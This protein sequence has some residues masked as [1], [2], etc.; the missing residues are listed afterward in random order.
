MSPDNAAR[1]DRRHFGALAAGTLAGAA[2][3][4][5]GGGLTLSAGRAEA[6]GAGCTVDPNAP[7]QQLRGVWVASVTNIDW[8]S[9]P[10]LPAAQQ[11]AELI[12]W[13]DLVNRLRLNT[14][15]L[16]V[17]P[18]ADAFWPSPYEPWSQYLTGT[19]G[20]DPGY[21]PLRFAVAAAHE[22]DIE[23][24][25]WFN[26]YRVS[27]QTDLSKLVPTHPARLHPDWVFPYGTTL[28][29][30]PGIPAVRQFVE[31]AILDAA[32]HYDIDGI[33]FDDYFYPYPIAGQ[34]LPDQATFASH[35]AGWDTIEDWRRNNINL[36]ISELHE[37]VHKIK[38]WLKFGVSPFGIW[39]NAS[40]DPAGSDTAGTQSYDANFADTRKWV[41]EQWLDYINP[42][43]YWNIGFAVADY[44]KL[45][46]WWSDQVTGTHVQLYLG[47]ANYKVG[48]PAQPAA[49]QDP[50]ELSRHLTLDQGLNVDGNVYFSA[51][52]V[53]ADVL[54][55]MSRLVADHYQHPALT[56][57]MPH[58]GG[59]APQPPA[60][61]R[62]DGTPGGVR[63]S[64]LDTDRPGSAASY[65]VY[66]F[67]GTRRLSD[68]DTAD[69]TSL[70]ATVRTAGRGQTY[71]DTTA[72]RGKTYSYAVSAVSRLSAE[73][74][75][76]AVRHVRA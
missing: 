71:T 50:A 20:K 8:P 48:N 44:A 47:E 37:R 3:L 30:N 27:L 74:R 66:R 19:Q 72:I 10:G 49:W 65:A 40:A 68:C 76:S 67:D 63:L 14:V 5:A 62:V 53:R 69:A 23:L 22:R 1:L 28:Y 34:T 18:T 24:H 60:I 73:S 59:R 45:A 58:L 12:A 36:L 13:F 52:D 41:R 54:G 9:K 43:I 4:A 6:A 46:S 16:Q 42:Q 57:A 29:Y 31:Q 7:K 61:A 11:Q 35:G 75:P 17:R 55:S 38:P 15:M 56:P 26:P 21:D 25:A 70:I 51:K 39:R 2:G 64:W 32:I 33:H